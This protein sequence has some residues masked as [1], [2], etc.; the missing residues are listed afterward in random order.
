[1]A[2]TRFF[3]IFNRT[4]SLIANAVLRTRYCSSASNDLFS[5]IS[6]L[7]H[8]D[9]SLVPVL[10]KWA[11]EGRK[12]KGF[13]LQRIVK[14]LRARRRYRQA[15]EVSEW[16]SGKVGNTFSP[17]DRAVQLDLIGRVRG[18]ESAESYFQN[19]GG[20]AKLAKIYGALLN[21]YVREG[22]VE[23]SLNHM[24][25]MK[26]LGFASSP[27]N[28]NDLMC[29]Y[30]NTGQL[31]KV[32][33]V[34][35]EMK[36]NGVS[37][38]NFSYRICMN[39]CAA[40]SDLSG[41][42][43]IL[44]EMDNQPHISVDWI[45]YSTVANIY[46]KAGLKERALVYLKKCEEKVTKD[47]LGYNHLVSLY[48][49]LGNKDEM[50]RLWG[51]AK[52]KCKKQVNRDYITM[53][54]SLVKLGELEEAEKLLQEWESSCQ[55]YDFR[56]PNVLLIGYC[57][58]G[59]V[60]KAEAMLRD[61]VKKQKTATPNSWSIIASGY[62]DKQNMEKAFQCMKEA[63]TLQAENKGWRP[64]PTLISSILSWLADNGDAEDVEAFVSSLENKVP[65]DR[66]LY[67]T[68]VKAYVRGGKQVNGLLESMKADKIDVDEETKT[69]LSLRQQEC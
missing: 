6:P 53:L 28:Y 21:C 19:L 48:A 15:L 31:E 51:L 49:S 11:E 12:I 34:L 7:G 38:D 37:P 45:T 17:G 24:Q 40:R 64:K 5:I 47:A 43:K 8:P 20:R 44:E 18:L 3:A 32:L 55:C 22:L 9:I 23:K 26:E 33:D 14:D 10:D 27:L 63:L 58:K 67:H 42:E 50:M 56:V 39:S 16:M 61:I 35:S 52:A 30:T 57:Q 1:M 36:E 13:E 68:L 25:K 65:K 66:E 59:L 54:G 69:I 41:V 4:Q 29:L 2:L 46:I 62:M 60:E